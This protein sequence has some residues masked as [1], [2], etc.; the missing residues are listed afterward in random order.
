MGIQQRCPLEGFYFSLFSSFFFSSQL[1]LIGQS[2][3][4]FRYVTTRKSPSRLL[5]CALH[6]Q[7]RPH[8]P[9]FR[10]LYFTWP[11][12]HLLPYL[13]SYNNAP[14]HLFCAFFA[15]RARYIEGRH[16][17]ALRNSSTI[18]AFESVSR[19]EEEREVLRA[20]GMGT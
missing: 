12:S 17:Y 15:H 1:R 5:P 16:I 3:L 7:H 10:P 13:T 11:Y 2:C 4:P 9:K 18:R 14:A 8:G 6:C 20:V 19:E